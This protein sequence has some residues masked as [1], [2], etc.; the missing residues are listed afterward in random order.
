MHP[1]M[2]R[3]PAM[4]L[5]LLCMP[6]ALQPAWAAAPARNGEAGGA[7]LSCNELGQ[8]L[9]ATG[10]WLLKHLTDGGQQHCNASVAGPHALG[11]TQ[12]GELGPRW[13]S[14]HCN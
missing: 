11:L 9:D 6:A 13:A 10:L 7:A 8:H 12:Q 1:C 5:A 2:A 14:M 3:W 4:L